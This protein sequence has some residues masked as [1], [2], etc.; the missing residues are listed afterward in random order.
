MITSEIEKFERFV[1]ERFIRFRATDDAVK[2]SAYLLAKRIL[3]RVAQVFLIQ[4]PNFGQVGA[5]QE[6]DIVNVINWS[7]R[8]RERCG[9]F[10]ESGE[11]L[12]SLM[13]EFEPIVSE[14]CSEEFR[15]GP[16]LDSCT[17]AYFSFHSQ[18][19]MLVKGLRFPRTWVGDPTDCRQIFESQGFPSLEDFFMRPLENRFQGKSAFQTTRS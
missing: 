12:K 3:E 8:L 2:L 18:F 17:Q 19:S 13:G 7:S 16:G 11:A 15:D 4:I 14:A 6:A 1:L 5:V 9:Q 10:S